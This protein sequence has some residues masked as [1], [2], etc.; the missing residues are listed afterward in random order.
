[1][2]GPPGPP[3]LCCKIPVELRGVGR[4]LFTSARPCF[5]PVR[6][7]TGGGSFRG[8][9]LVRHLLSPGPV[10]ACH[11]VSPEDCSLP[12]VPSSS[13]GCSRERRFCLGYTWTTLSSAPSSVCTNYSTGAS[14]G[15]FPAECGYRRKRRLPRTGPRASRSPS[16][17]RLCP[18]PIPPPCSPACSTPGLHPHLAPSP[19]SDPHPTLLQSGRFAKRLLAPALSPSEVRTVLGR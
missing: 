13:S 11:L 19:W 7:L 6:G 5:K 12:P 1:M 14:V 16:M 17:P 4:G 2:L 8:E 10:T 15:C 18:H 3:T 9:T